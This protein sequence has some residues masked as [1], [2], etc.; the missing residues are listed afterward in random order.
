MSEPSALPSGWQPPCLTGG[1]ALGWRVLRAVR[2]RALARLLEDVN[3]PERA[4]HLALERV[5]DSARGTRFAREHGLDGVYDLDAYRAAVPIRPPEDLEP[6]LRAQAAGELGALTRHRVRSFV[7]TSGTTGSPRQ[8][9]VT[10]PWARCVAQ[11]Q[12]AWVL[13]MVAEQPGLTA[14]GARALASVGRAV[15]GTTPGGAPFGSNTGRMRAAQ[16]WWVRLAYAVP[17]MVSEIEDH[18]LRTYVFLRLALAVDV[19]SWTTANPSTVLGVCRALQHDR[20][21][22]AADLVDGTLCRGPARAL[23]RATRRRLRPWIWRRRA[24]PTD[25][26]PA[27]FWPNL[28]CVNCWK[29]GQAGFYLDR[30]P[31]AL[32]ADPPVREVGISASEGHL[33]VPL[34]SSWDGGVA[35]VGGHLIELVPE[36]GGPPCLPHQVERGGI[37]RVVLSTTAG[38]YR[39]DLGDLVSVEGWFGRSPCL[40]FLRR[41]GQVRSMTGEKLTGEQVVQV[42]RAALGSEVVGFVMCPILGDPGHYVLAFEGPVA[43]RALEVDRALRRVNV[44]YDSKRSSERLAPVRVVVLRPGTFDAW[45]RRRAAQGAAE[46][47]IKEPI[48]GTIQALRDLQSIG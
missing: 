26:R 18:D 8:L 36:R 37:Y 14:P 1:G 3:S 41:A 29:G 6:W 34:H 2:G 7:Q 20:E 48:F 40:R 46:G 42:A 27:G 33:A 10:A 45:R 19:R 22:L 12:A 4:Q 23:D 11:A 44:E 47:Q 30:L 28:L 38:L 21:A 5:L 32:G 25:W 39:Y 9:A 35:V 16:A 24:L 17:A 15:E 31:R 43:P 13:A